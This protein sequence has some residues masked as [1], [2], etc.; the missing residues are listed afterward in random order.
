M[1][2]DPVRAARRFTA[3]LMPWEGSN[4]ETVVVAR[5]GPRRGGLR[6]LCLKDTRLKFSLHPDLLNFLANHGVVTTGGS[7]SSSLGG[8]GGGGGSRRRRRRRRRPRTRRC[9]A[10][11]ER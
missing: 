2:E 7:G 10:S 1:D 5:S 3:D 4:H 9:T 8:G 6:L 11:W